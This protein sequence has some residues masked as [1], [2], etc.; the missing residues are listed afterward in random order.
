MNFFIYSHAADIFLT[1]PGLST[2]VH[3]ILVARCIFVRIRNFI[4][5]RIAATLQLLLFFFIAVFA[6]NPRDYMPPKDTKD[7][8]D[9]FDWPIFFHV[10]VLLL[11]LIT[12]LNDGTLIAIGYDRVVPLKTPEKWNKRVLFSVAGVLSIVALASSLLLLWMLL[13]S[14]QANSWLQHFGI[15]GLS[16]GEITTAIYLKVSI[17]DFLTLFSSRTGGDWFWS[18]RPAPIL[19]VAGFVALSS[20]TLVALF[21]PSSTVDGI[22]T[23]GLA[24][25]QPILALAI[26]GY[27]LVWWLVQDAAKVLLYQFLMAFN[28]FGINDTGIVVLPDSTRKYIEQNRE[29][30]TNPEMAG[31][32]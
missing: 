30:L 24:N 29:R 7:F 9:T 5:Y 10:P 17:S 23:L 8:P 1:Q 4:I 31:G 3:G 22:F 11:M 6:F 26:W 32:H 2:I 21:Y 12:L 15:G 28:I 25:R 20:S 27:C 19:L 16:F 13:S 14:W 18:T